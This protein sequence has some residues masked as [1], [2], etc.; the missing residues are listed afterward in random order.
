M[1]RVSLRSILIVIVLVAICAGCA[2]NQQSQLFTE[3]AAKS[4]R[5]VTPAQQTAGWAVNWWM[6]R[7]DTNNERLAEGNIDLLWIGDSITHGW[8]NDGKKYWDM[9]YA[10]RNAINMG[11]SG[12]QTQH[13]L[14]RLENYQYGDIS[15]KLA[16]LMIGTNNSN[17]NDFT[18]EEIADGIIAICGNL[19]TRFPEMKI[20]ML[21]I[22]PRG[23][24]PSA[25]REK[26]AAASEIASQLADGKMIHYLDIN[27][28]FLTDDGT[29]PRTIMP[30][31]LHPNEE[32]YRIWS[33][34]IESTI[35]DL[36]GE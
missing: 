7:F 19:R 2:S 6:P 29:L 12:D 36:M 11:Y 25:Q 5:A 31:L 32:G 15:P 34:A 13:V 30:D 10:D 3:V 23:E 9:Y 35:A 22:F 16:I 1:K 17:G 21:A 24:G 8:E 33:E 20:L 14:W 27:Q 18:A 4:H 26:N 28:G